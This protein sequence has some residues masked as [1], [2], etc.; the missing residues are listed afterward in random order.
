MFSLLPFTFLFI[1]LMIFGTF[2]SISSFNWLFVWVGL[3][4]NLMGFIPLLVYSGKCSSAESGVKYF[5]I[6]ALGS[7]LFAGGSCLVL[8]SMS[9]LDLV[10]GL[11]GSSFPDFY[12][13][14]SMILILS[15]LFLK[16]GCFPFYFWL[17]SV[18]L[19]T[20]WFS[21][22]FLLTWQKLAPFF[23]LLS[24]G[25]SFFS[26]G[27]WLM[28]IFAVFSSLFGGIGGIGETYLR[29]IL[30]YSSIGHSGWMLYS[31]LLGF[32]TFCVYFF[33]Y[34]FISA[35]LFVILSFSGSKNMGYVGCFSKSLVFKFSMMGI[36]LSLGGMPPLLGFFGKWVV[37]S[38]GMMSG[39]AL[40][41]LLILGSLLSLYY[42]LVLFF[43]VFFSSGSFLF[44]VNSTMNLMGY[45]G[46][47]SIFLLVMAVGM[48]NLFGAALCF[49]F[50]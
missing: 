11:I 3:E 26:V 43:G 8:G 18:V 39:G 47:F 14:F 27:Y 21:C 7:S 15:S 4:V 42:Y 16:L 33:I 44:S 45:D 12:Y 50:I 25:V 1:F 34:F 20:S 23:I 30:A 40:P 2:I 38:N 41:I 31:G 46:N 6:Q 32:S 48:V 36:L 28:S 24:V 29:S 35:C 19:G 17:P 9:S 10:F 5:L 37:L 49:V 13:V 22:F